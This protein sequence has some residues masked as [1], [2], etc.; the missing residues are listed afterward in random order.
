[1]SELSP[2]LGL[3]FLMAAQAQKHVTH[4]EA[5]LRLDQVT[6]LVLQALAATEPP[7][8]PA[9]GQVWALG[10]AP[11]GDWA[12]QGGDLAAWF[13]GAWHFV[14]PAPGW[15]AG[16][17]AELR[18]FDGSD[19][20]APGAVTLDN[21]PG[22][23]INAT[24]DAT[25]RLSVSAPATLLGHEG[26]GHQLKLN[27]AADTDTASLLFQTDFSGRAEMGT[28]GTDDFSVKVSADGSAWHDGLVVA[29][30]SGAVSA[31]NGL[32]AAT[33][34][35]AGSPVYAQSTILGT[36]SQS[37]GVPTGAIIQR[38]SNSN[39]E[40]ARFADG[41]QM[42]WRT[43]EETGIDIDNGSGGA[44]M[45][46]QYA[47]PWA[48]AFSG[49]PTAAVSNR[50]D[51]TAAIFPLEDLTSSTEIR[52]RWFSVALRS[53]VNAGAQLIGIGRWF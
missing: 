47:Y 53:N 17:G 4:N 48:A 23:G 24:H 37:A 22:L 20:V 12:G 31:P 15:Q 26:A 42:C 32:D 36:V 8:D 9:E 34:S 29:R 38:G 7:E 5:L 43:V 6:Q 3:P 21:L 16:F 1:M 46:S 30:A 2:R 11:A 33:L 40:F 50:R 51:G 45:T 19:W 35:R 44:H 25:N 18:I 28:A 49:T 14:T 13:D 52:V 27:K 39:G 10:P 41:T